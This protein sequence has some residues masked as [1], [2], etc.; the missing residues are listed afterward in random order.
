VPGRTYQ[1]ALEAL[2][3]FS[4]PTALV[5]RD[6]VLQRLVTAT[7]AHSELGRI[8]T[9]LRNIT[10]PPERLQRETGILARRLAV[11]GIGVSLLLILLLGLRSGDWLQALLAGVAPSM[12]VLPEKYPV[13]LT[14]FPALEGW[15][16]ARSEVLTRRLAGLA[17]GNL[18]RGSVIATLGDDDPASR[19]DGVTVCARIV[20]QQKLRIVQALQRSGAVVAV[21]GDSVND[22][23]ALRAADGGVAMGK[24][25]T[26]VARE[27]AQ[28]TLL[29]DR[30]ASPV[31]AIGTGRLIFS[32]MRKSMTYVMAMHVPIARMALLPALFGWPVSLYPLH[33]VFLEL[34]IDPGCSLAFENEPAEPDLMQRPLR[35][36]S[37]P[38]FGAPGWPGHCCGVHGRWRCWRRPMDGRWDGFRRHRRARSP[39][40]PWCY[41][42]SRCYDRIARERRCGRAAQ[43]QPGVLDHCRRALGLLCWHCT[44][45]RY[46]RCF[47]LSRHR[48]RGWRA[49]RRWPC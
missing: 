40:Q 27:A 22:A 35:S 37:E 39:F 48:P 47:G 38:L 14:V 23:P 19:L 36:R 2:R 34:V 32:N 41:A 21:T 9:E 20:P 16:L 42:T 3:G 26:D 49:R 13:I 5:L 7:G 1:R 25:G 43:R 33:I 4:S 11:L 29:D 6:G 24:R 15:R 10:P 12:S 30:F 44:L 17:E 28:V 8:G 18:L 31:Q 46:R 45:P